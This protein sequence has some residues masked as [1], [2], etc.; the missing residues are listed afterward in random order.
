MCVVSGK[1]YRDYAQAMFESA[2]EFFH[3]ADDIWCGLLDG[4]EGWPAATLYR[5]HVLLEEPLPET[6]YLYLVDADMRWEGHV[7]TE[8]LGDLVATRHPGFV[9]R[10][11]SALPYERRAE[12]A[13]RVSRGGTY[14]AGGFVGGRCDRFLDLSR[15]IK[16]GIDRDDEQ[17]IV[18]V[19]H[20]ESH[21]N[22]QLAKTPPTLTLPPSFCYPDND[23]AYLRTWPERYE[24]KLVAVDKTPAERAGR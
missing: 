3:P 22:A 12:S 20:D 24:R 23:S 21:L 4:R 10:P 5:H 13:A 18:A 6:D 14:Y 2:A 11:A 9:G 17:G 15:R 19:W 7:G 1:V 16:D 8:V